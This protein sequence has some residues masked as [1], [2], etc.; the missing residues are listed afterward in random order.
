MLGLFSL[1]TGILAIVL[2]LLALQS[3]Q[4]QI[5]APLP[6]AQ[7]PSDP[8]INT[9]ANE[10]EPLLAAELAP[11]AEPKLNAA[12][13]NLLPRPQP[14]AMPTPVP[15]PTIPWMEFNKISILEQPTVMTIQPGCGDKAF[16]SPEFRILPWAAD[17][18]DRGEFDITRRTAVAWEHLGYTGLWIHSGSDWAG[19]PLAASPLQNYLERKG[20]W[21]K[22][23]PV[24]FDQNAADCLIGGK[25][26]LK[27]GDQ[28]LEGKVTAILRVPTADVEEVS[29]HVMDLV[30]YLA[31]TYPDSG[32]DK[33]KAPELLL[34]FC[35]RLLTGETPD[36]SLPDYS[37]TRIIV[38][39]DFDSDISND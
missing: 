9:T 12:K 8:F 32:F 24:E 31:K 25:V 27:L 6:V 16:A 5:A 36:Y 3:Y 18:F 33:L 37:R 11:T 19:S 26:S 22:R 20:G 21:L 23:T 17:I 34:Y 28:L 39:M 15:T 1:S 4:P 2:G 38:A 14:T 13:K 30:P 10:A 7:A 29:T 35:G